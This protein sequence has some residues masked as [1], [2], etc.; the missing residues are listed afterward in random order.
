MMFNDIQFE[1][2][3]L[4]LIRLGKTVQVEVGKLERLDY[5]GKLVS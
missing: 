4:E 1:G 3:D 2:D 5:F